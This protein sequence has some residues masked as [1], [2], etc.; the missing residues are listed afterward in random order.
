MFRNLVGEA[1][2]LTYQF[3]VADATD[4][5]GTIIQQHKSDLGW[6]LKVA[7]I[8]QLERERSSCSGSSC[9]TGL[10]GRSV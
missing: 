3:V 2:L 10:Y 4:T 9:E 6:R 7:G 8:N 5:R 1:S